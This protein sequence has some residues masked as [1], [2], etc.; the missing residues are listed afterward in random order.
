MPRL[1]LGVILPRGVRS[2]LQNKIEKELKQLDGH[3]ISPPEKWHLTLLFIGN[4]GVRAE[5]KIKDQLVRAKLFP[6]EPITLG[7]PAPFGMFGQH[8]L[9][10]HAKSATDFL[11]RLHNACM[12]MVPVAHSHVFRPHVTIAR[13]KHPRGDFSL[14][15]LNTRSWTIDFLP[16]FLS[17][18]ESSQ[19]EGVTHYRV[20]SQRRFP[21]K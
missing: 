7:G 19:R 13:T 17:L 11:T 10:M 5:E 15:K 12:R 6:A 18:I 9:F 14:E 4:V 2:P 16:P 3:T 20:L 8:I 21:R 1:F